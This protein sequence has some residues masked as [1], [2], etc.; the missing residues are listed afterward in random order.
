MR[1]TEGKTRANTIANAAE[2]T[3]T[4]W[5]S[6]TSVDRPTTRPMSAAAPATVITT[7]AKRIVDGLTSERCNA[8]SVRA[9]AKGN[10]MIPPPRKTPVNGNTTI[11]AMHSN[12]TGKKL[13]GSNRASR[14]EPAAVEE[15]GAV[16]HRQGRGRRRADPGRSPGAVCPGPGGA[17][18]RPGY[19][20]A[21][22]IPA[23]DP[24]K[25]LAAWMEW[26]SGAE[27]PGRVMA[28]LKTAGM[29]ELLRQLVDAR[30][31]TS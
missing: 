16:T 17:V 13:V 31:K 1:T 23:P 20:P 9:A 10:A 7:M 22:D 15:G 3:V 29:P 30:A 5:R 18:G 26:E 24:E 2:E 27:T 4:R 12:S 21:M 11:V 28:N 25:L 8:T 14:Q 19:P 6:S